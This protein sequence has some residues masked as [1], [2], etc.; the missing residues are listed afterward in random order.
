MAIGKPFITRDVTRTDEGII[1]D[2][3]ASKTGPYIGRIGRLNDQ[4]LYPGNPRFYATPGTHSPFIGTNGV[5]SF[6]TR[7]ES[8]AWLQGI[9][10]A[11][12]DWL[13]YALANPQPANHS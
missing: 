13:A 7:A 12:S 9:H 8:A 3:K 10:D 2:V 6:K 11:K 1:Y 4:I 5:R